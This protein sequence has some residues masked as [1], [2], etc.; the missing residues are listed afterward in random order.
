MENTM[1]TIDKLKF[2]AATKPI[3]QPP[4]VQR[5]NKLSNKLWEQIELV[6]C[7]LNGTQ[8][9]IKK[10]KTVKAA[11]GTA[12]RVQ[13]NKRIKPWWFQNSDGKLCV[14]IRY[15]AKVLELKRGMP[16]IQVADL[17]G[18]LEGLA[19]IKAEVEKGSFDEEIE[20]ASG[21]LKANF[22]TK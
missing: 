3:N 9:E 17:D 12:K 21:A 14:S 7:Q 15:G 8:L 5:R 2:V 4:I 10:E 20:L 19:I 11:D 16:S 6:K 13:I 1:A 18:L 22:K